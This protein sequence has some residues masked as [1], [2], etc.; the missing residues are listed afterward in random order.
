MFHWPMEMMNLECHHSFTRSFERC[1][2]FD[3]GWPMVR[4]YSREKMQLFYPKLDE[5][6]ARLDTPY[7]FRLLPKNSMHA[8][9]FAANTFDIST[10]EIHAHKNGNQMT[11]NETKQEQKRKKNSYHFGWHMSNG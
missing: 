9:C 10:A 7:I 4:K 5:I 3:F 2:S 1:F 11:E 6:N 8:K